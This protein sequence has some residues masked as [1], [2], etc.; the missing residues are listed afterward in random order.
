MDCA[1]ILDV[2]DPARGG[3]ESYACSLARAL[4]EASWRVHIVTREVAAPRR[5]AME[6]HEV[7]A[8][9]TAFYAAADAKRRELAQAGAFV[10]VSFRHPG[11]D[12]VFMPLG[13]LLAASLDARR[14]HEPTILRAPRR[15]ARALSAKTRGFLARERA[16]FVEPGGRER[17][18][19]ANAT[20]VTHDIEQRFPL[21]E[22]RV[23]LLGLPV[24][25][26]RFRIAGDVER[27]A[28]RAAL[29][30]RCGLESFTAD[31]RIV[32]FVG[33]DA[34]RKGLRVALA[35]FARLRKRKFAARLVLAGRGTSSFTDAA[36]G[37]HGL[38]YI[39]DMSALFDACDC[40]LAPSIED[41]YSLCALEAMA[42]G[43]PVVT[44]ARNGVACELGDRRL[45]R[46]VDDARDVSGFDAACLALLDEHALDEDRR[47]QRRAAVEAQ[48]R[49]LHFESVLE[50]LRE[51]AY[52]GSR[53]ENQRL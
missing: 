38:G 50:L 5:D 27:E 29:A 10:S 33:H 34:K 37:V 43:V 17:L 28:A 46:V 9:G 41:N 16:F 48:R 30:V 31:E 44:S 12:D 8:P 24:D 45:A 3:L 25:F 2:W 40:L 14:A 4:R 51:R 52:L 36:R 42:S 53:N 7:P 21:F 11:L 6:F 19:V 22:G 23:E 32:L 47:A 39:D 15:W 18:V 20:H 13:G 49:E 35:A 1:L 26:E